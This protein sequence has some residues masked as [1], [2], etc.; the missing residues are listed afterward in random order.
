MSDIEH[1]ERVHFEELRDRLKKV[2]TSGPEE[3]AD[4]MCVI[5][6][7]IEEIEEMEASYKRICDGVVPT[8]DVL[9]RDVKL[10]RYRLF[11]EALTIEDKYIDDAMYNQVVEMGRHSQ[12]R[13]DQHPFLVNEDG[14][15]NYSRAKGWFEDLCKS[16]P[17][18][19]EELLRHYV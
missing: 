2:E 4:R 5:M 15:V 3:D 6:D 12:A 11:L 7:R 8:H 19:A 14:S 1:T 9:P 18:Q 16:K 10:E 17:K 13:R